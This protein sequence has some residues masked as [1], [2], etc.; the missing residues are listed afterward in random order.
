MTE[1]R[2]KYC[3]R[4]VHILSNF[5]FQ[6][7]ADKIPKCQW[8][9][10]PIWWPSKRLWKPWRECIKFGLSECGRQTS[11]NWRYVITWLIAYRDYQN[12][13]KFHIYDFF[14]LKV[15]N[16]SLT[17]KK[18][19][20]PTVRLTMVGPNQFLWLILQNTSRKVLKMVL[21]YCDRNIR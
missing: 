15:L 18:K 7:K 4:K 8:K 1:R 19:R 17:V 12:T 11:V 10:C 13:A 9:T 6:E 3:N 2:K 20:L 5:F 16:N 21:L 14:T